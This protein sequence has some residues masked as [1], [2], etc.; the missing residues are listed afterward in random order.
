MPQPDLLPP[1]DQRLA[2]LQTAMVGL[3]WLVV[4]GLWLFILPGVLWSM[5]DE[6]Q[7]LRAHFTWVGLRYAIAYNLWATLGLSLCLGMTASVLVWQSRNILFG[8]PQREQYRLEQLL[9]QIESQG[10]RHPLW[11]WL[12][13][14]QL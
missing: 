11:R 12:H 1:T 14:E 5:R 10:R 9:A 2:K 6:I 8:R 13:R 7:L 3:R 4:A